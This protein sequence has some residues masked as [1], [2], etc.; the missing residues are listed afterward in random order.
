MFIQKSQYTYD[1]VCHIIEEE[2]KNV[3]ATKVKFGVL[4]ETIFDTTSFI[5]KILV[6]PLAYAASVFN[7]F[8][9]LGN[10]DTYILAV[11]ILVLLYFILYGRTNNGMYYITYNILA[12]LRIKPSRLIIIEYLNVIDDY[13]KLRAL[14]D[15]IET[16]ED[17]MLRIQDN[18]VIMRYVKNGTDR[19]QVY[20]FTSGL[21]ANIYDKTN[22]VL[23]IG[24]L[25]ALFTSILN[26]NN[27]LKNYN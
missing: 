15:D 12:I 6:L 2:R 24:W 17:C 25:D 27:K 4:L 5:H 10:I 7:F 20:E 8:P 26:T 18:S 22:N 11:L 21:I 13:K 16:L 23:N 9:R 1:E 19:V 14:Q 3:G